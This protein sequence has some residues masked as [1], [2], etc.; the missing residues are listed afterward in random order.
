MANT[1]RVAGLLLGDQVGDETVGGE[2][3]GR[4]RPHHRHAGRAERSDVTE[5]GQES[6]RGVGRREHDPVVRRG[7]GRLD[8]QRRPAVKWIGDGNHR[9]LDHVR[10]RVAQS[11]HQL[12]GLRLGRESRRPSCR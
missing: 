4:G 7:T 6:L 1:S 2:R 11:R 8:A 10:T 3:A 5:Q 12:G 9:E